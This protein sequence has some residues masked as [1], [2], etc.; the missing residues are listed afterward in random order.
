[1]IQNDLVAT[2]EKYVIDA[3]DRIFQVF[4]TCCRPALNELFNEQTV[5][6]TVSFHGIQD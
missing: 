4:V 6:R 5:N 1:M 2:V 3:D